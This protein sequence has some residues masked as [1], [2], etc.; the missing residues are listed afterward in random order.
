VELVAEDSVTVA[1][2]RSNIQTMCQTIGYRVPAF[3][4]HDHLSCAVG[5]TA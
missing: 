1:D 5:L 2:V 4:V 3:R